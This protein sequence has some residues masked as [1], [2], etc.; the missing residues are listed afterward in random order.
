MRMNPYTPGAGVT[1]NFLSGREELLEEARIVLEGLQRGYMQRPVIYYGLRGVGKTVILNVLE[2]FAEN[3]E[4]QYEHIEAN[5]DKL[6]TRRFSA[7]VNRILGNLGK[8]NRVSETLEK[9]KTLIRSF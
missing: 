9:C 1:P 4:I 5:E 7:A 3:M 6:F 2:G 8:K